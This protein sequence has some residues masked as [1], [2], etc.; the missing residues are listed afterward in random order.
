MKKLLMLAA[1]ATIAVGVQ[2]DELT[3]AGDILGGDGTTWSAVDNWFNLTAGAPATAIPGAGDHAYMQD[4]VYG[5]PITT[6]PVVSG[7]VGTTEGVVV[8]KG[9]SGSLTVNAGGSLSTSGNLLLAEAPG[10]S[11][12]VVNN[13]TLGASITYTH[14][15]IAT[16]ENNGTLNTTDLVLGHL[17]GSDST[18]SNTGDINTTG[19]FY[20]TV[21]GNSL[22]NMNGGTVTVGNFN[23]VQAGTGHLQLDGGTITA[24]ILGIDGNANNTIDITEGV[25]V[26]VGDH[27]GGLDW[28]AGNGEGGMSFPVITAYGGAGT[29]IA[30]YDSGSNLTTLYAIPEP[31]TLSLVAL[32]GGGM[33]WIRKRF[34][35]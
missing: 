29:V 35:A 5:N 32:L 7:N 8:G 25:L 20:L 13:G 24:G 19:L 26:A 11:G 27:S 4:D 6:M 2:A 21:G 10:V 33:L 15:G 22:F 9:T 28:M 30:D 3:W 16:F 1:V 31:A 12:S 18:F 23:L 17:G 14:A 34:M